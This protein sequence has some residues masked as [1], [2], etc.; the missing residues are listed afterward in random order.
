MHRK[1]FTLGKYF[2]QLGKES[3]KQCNHVHTTKIELAIIN[4]G[5]LPSPL[6]NH[7]HSALQVVSWQTQSVF[8][9]ARTRDAPSLS[10]LIPLSPGS[11]YFIGK[12][13]LPP[14]PGH[15]NAPW[16]D[17]CPTRVYLMPLFLC[18]PS[19]PYHIFFK[20]A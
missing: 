2:P 1:S 19:N 10:S 7:V 18:P 17:W 14:P 6:Q 20:H 15:R 3:K 9:L 8:V 13:Y 16:G 12:F 11:P 4:G 5:L